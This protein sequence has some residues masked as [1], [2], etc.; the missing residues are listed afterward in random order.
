MKFIICL[1]L[2]TTEAVKI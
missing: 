1:L 2:A